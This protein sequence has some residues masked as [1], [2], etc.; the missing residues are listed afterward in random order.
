M[1]MFGCVCWC[2]DGPA[3]ICLCMSVYMCVC[4]YVCIRLNVC[5]CVYVNVC[6]CV[7]LCFKC[8]PNQRVSVERILG[9][10]STSEHV[11]SAD[12]QVA[13]LK[14]ES[15]ARGAICRNIKKREN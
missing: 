15:H 12:V 5:V 10:I 7:C 6:T 1:C 2:V 4:V 3:R 13:E 14:C 9:S 8:Q 11:M